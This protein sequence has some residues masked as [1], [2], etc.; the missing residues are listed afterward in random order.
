M[1]LEIDGNGGLAGNLFAALFL[2]LG[3]DALKL[4]TLVQR[5]GLDFVQVDWHR[6]FSE[7]GRLT[8]WLQ[9]HNTDQAGA[10][11]YDEMRER[12]DEAWLPG[13]VGDIAKS[14]LRR[15]NEVVAPRWL[16][17]PLDEAIFIGDEVADTLIDVCAAPLLWDDIGRPDITVKG[18][19][20]IGTTWSEFIRQILPPVPTTNAHPELEL[21]SPTGA[22]ILHAFW[23][24]FTP[25]GRQ[26]LEVGAA[27]SY[28]SEGLWQ[29]PV[30]AAMYNPDF[31]A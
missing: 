21:T 23:K 22:A 1:Q 19:L 27:G 13:D 7:D 25:E 8:T 12:I 15:R 4:K 28:Y 10:L 9:Y 11:T 26:V 14:I 18:P 17:Q 2:S 16:G 6:S 5:L 29:Q 24:P 31:S 20:A 30:R 3:A